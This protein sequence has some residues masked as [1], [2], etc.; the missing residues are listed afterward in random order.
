MFNQQFTCKRCKHRQNNICLLLHQE[1]IDEDYGCVKFTDSPYVCE[2][3]GTHVILGTIFDGMEYPYHLLCNDCAS[4]IGTCTTCTLAQICTFRTDNSVKEPPVIPQT[5]RQGN[6]IIQ[7]QIKNP[8]RIKLTC[9]KCPCYMSG[10][11]LKEEGIGCENHQL[12]IEGW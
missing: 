12:N 6:T 8:A 9:E 7:T 1:I 10:E 4:K 2:L 5:I 3:C 11:C